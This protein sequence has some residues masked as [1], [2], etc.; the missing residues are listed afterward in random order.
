VYAEF[1]ITLLWAYSLALGMITWL[2]SRYV[3][4]PP[5]LPLGSP[6]PGWTGVVLATTGLVQVIVGMFLDR[7][8]DQRFLRNFFW[9]IWYPLAYWAIAWATTLVAFPR[10]LARRR[11]K[12]A[13]WTSPDR[14]V[15][16]A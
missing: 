1:V 2:V 11:G 10:A 6:I 15:R 5:W 12:R 7:R 16:P 14:G 3:A 13:R 4:M 8:Y 9:V